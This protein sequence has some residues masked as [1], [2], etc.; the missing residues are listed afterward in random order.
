MSLD[1]A[2]ACSKLTTEAACNAAT[3]DR[4]FW[5]SMDKAKGACL[6]A[7]FAEITAFERSGLTVDLPTIPAALTCPGSRAAEFFSC[8]AHPAAGEP[9][10][11][12]AMQG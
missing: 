9:W 1:K 7:D 11:C 10:G 2:E 5:R 12:R 8:H 4:C 3:T 6:A